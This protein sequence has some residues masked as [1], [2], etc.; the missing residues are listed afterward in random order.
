MHT[1]PQNERSELIMNSPC[2]YCTRV[3]EPQNCENKLCK[4]WQAWF[5]DRWET[6]RAQIRAQME[7]APVQDIGIPLGG[8]RYVSPHRMREYLEHDPCDQCLY[9]KDQCGVPC[10]TRKRWEEMKK[11]VKK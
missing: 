7:T 9:P 1:V 3:K 10:P 11:E 8:N 4:D 2:L 6:I 5:I